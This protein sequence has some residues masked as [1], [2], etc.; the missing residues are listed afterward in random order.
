[1]CLFRSFVH[2]LVWSNVSYRLILTSCTTDTNKKI[3]VDRKIVHVQFN[4]KYDKN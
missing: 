1:M 4:L 2:F 3:F